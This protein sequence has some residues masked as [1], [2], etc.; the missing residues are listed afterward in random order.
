MAQNQ[1]SSADEELESVR[2]TINE[3]KAAAAE[4]TDYKPSEQAAKAV[5]EEE[6]PAREGHYSPS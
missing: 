4:A 3:A 6:S 5:P 1:R 2:E